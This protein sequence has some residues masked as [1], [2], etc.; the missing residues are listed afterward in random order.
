MEKAFICATQEERIH[1]RLSQIVPNRTK[2][3]FTVR[4][5]LNDMIIDTSSLDKLVI[6]NKT[7]NRIVNDVVERISTIGEV[8]VAKPAA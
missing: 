6:S 8:V 4:V 2:R 3:T 7:I 1:H 5:F